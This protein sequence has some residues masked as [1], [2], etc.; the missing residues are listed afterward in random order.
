[1]S[2][3]SVLVQFRL[4][5]DEPLRLRWL[6]EDG[7]PGDGY[8]AQITAVALMDG[9][10]LLMQRSAIVEQVEPEPG[11]GPSAYVLMFNGMVGYAEDHP[12]RAIVDALV[13]Q[14]VD[15]DLEF[16][17]DETGR[18]AIENIDYRIVERPRGH[19]RKLRR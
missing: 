19:A 12:D 8:K 15:Y 13:D 17:H 14:E 9:A 16:V 18:V 3:P 2:E 4:D 10:R 7:A 6:A 5:R 11:G 1:M